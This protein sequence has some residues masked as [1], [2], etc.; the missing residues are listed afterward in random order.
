MDE[1]PNQIYWQSW[2]HS[3][4]SSFQFF[5]K[6]WVIWILILIHIFLILPCNFPFDF[7]KSSAQTTLLYFKAVWIGIFADHIIGSFLLLENLKM[8]DYGAKPALIQLWKT[9]RVTIKKIWYLTTTGLLFICMTC[10]WMK[11]LLEDELREGGKSNERDHPISFIKSK[12]GLNVVSSKWLI[13]ICVTMY[14]WEQKIIGSKYFSFHIQSCKLCCSR[15]P[16][17]INVFLLALIFNKNQIK[18]RSPIKFKSEIL[19]KDLLHSTFHAELSVGLCGQGI[20][21]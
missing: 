9:T 2:K 10:V 14:S 4:I 5:S 8:L 1:K 7:F 11:C 20:R 12:I 16:S 18:K 15:Q 3:I 17:C 13:L 6:C 19:Q 21:Y